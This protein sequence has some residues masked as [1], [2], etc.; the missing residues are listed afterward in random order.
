MSTAN[1]S[2]R[3]AASS[4]LSNPFRRGAEGPPP[5]NEVP[6]LFP[7]LLVLCV[8]LIVLT[9]LAPL[10]RLF[11]HV[12]IDY[13]EGW[14]AYWSAAAMERAPLYSTAHVFASDN[15]P[16]LSFYVNGLLGTVIGDYI[17][18]GRI[19]ALASMLAV[20][21]L[22]GC[23]VRI[24]GGPKR[25]AFASAI[26][27]I[28]YNFLYFGQFVAVNNPQW[29]GQA[30]ALAGVLPLLREQGNALR[31]RTVFLAAGAMILGGLVKHNQ[32]AL[33]L[34]VSVWLVIRDRS[35]FAKWCFAGSALA[36]LACA[37]LYL[38]YGPAIY[39]ELIS[40]KRTV[41]IVNFRAGLSKIG[42]LVPLACVGAISLR[43]R[44]ADDR[45]MLLA[46]Y[47]AFGLVLGAL[48]RLGS[49][50]YINAHYDALIGLVILSGAFLGSAASGRIGVLQDRWARM[51]LLLAIL[52][53]L[54]LVAPRHVV[55]SISDARDVPAQEAIWSRMIADVARA[56]DPA[57]C[58][59]LAV[60]YWAGKPLELDFFAYG[61]KLR[62]GTRP[63]ALEHIIATRSARI[64]I[65]DRGFRRQTGYARLPAPFPALFQAHYR[66]VRTAPG[67]I[68]ELVPR[69]S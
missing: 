33:P 19:V 20:A 10:A 4:L 39:A 24:L 28:L 49:G 23:I 27:F 30:I 21:V 38:I 58:E 47:A 45:W 16:P 41:D 53:P 55:R 56:P 52:F 5:Q 46:L 9:S 26:V 34:A 13:G 8:A 32:F 14:N 15:Y 48:Q 12:S 66:V 35:A 62:T 65:L 25:W 69:G 42:C 51:A 18:A 11:S 59:V 67:E 68:D 1:H 2:S 3:S 50:V 63:A 7:G 43:W 64:L 54:F 6:L 61:Q 29:L 37:A 40:F 44:R 60:C 22:I 31:W 57:L 36:A 17:I